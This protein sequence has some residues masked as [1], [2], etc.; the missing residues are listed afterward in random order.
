MLTQRIPSPET[1]YFAENPSISSLNCPIK[2]VRCL[3]F[4]AYLV[5]AIAHGC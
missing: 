3:H 5:Y 2:T 1:Q 4:A